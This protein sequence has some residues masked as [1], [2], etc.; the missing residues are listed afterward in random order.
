MRIRSACVCLCV[1]L[2]SYWL[3]V[4]TLSHNV[5]LWARAQLSDC[6]CFPS[7]NDCRNATHY[8]LWKRGSKWAFFS[9]AQE[10]SV[11]KSH[12]HGQVWWAWP[13][14]CVRVTD[15]SVDSVS[16][17]WGGQPHKLFTRSNWLAE[18]RLYWVTSCW[19]HP[20]SNMGIHLG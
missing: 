15:G 12:G 20:P 17:F 8:R 14:P 11:E 5:S 13:S 3:N 10:A 19:P 7:T 1:C 18:W 4:F 2:V 9:H 6:V 16:F